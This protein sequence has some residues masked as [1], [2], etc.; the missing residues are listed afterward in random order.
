VRRV[1]AYGALGSTA[2]SAPV[3]FPQ[4][5][6]ALG[7]RVT[8]S[9]DLESPATVD[10]T[11]EDAGGTVVRTIRAGEALDAGRHAFAWDGRDDAGALVPRGTY[12]TVV[13]ATDGEHRATQRAAVVADAFRVTVSDETPGRGQRITITAVS[14]EV[15]DGNPRLK[16]FQ[17]GRSAW[18]E[19]MKK[20]APKTYRVTV[21]LKSGSAGT[22]RLRVAA[23]DDRGASQFSNVYLPLH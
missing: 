1:V 5:G 22:L 4:D 12:R 20:I 21:E 11:V 13:S 17:P 16:V 10:W 14:A 9:F 2:A 19:S 23:D 6:D 18:A 8:F 15:L 7:S 3:F